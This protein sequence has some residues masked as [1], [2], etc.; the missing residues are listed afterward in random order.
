M[1]EIAKLGHLIEHWM[2]H[3][4]EHAKT[5]RLWAEKAKALGREDVSE[6]LAVIADETE[7]LNSFFGKARAQ[8]KAQ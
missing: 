2:E 3:N 5:Y 1:E 8:I 6:T 7:K 4:E